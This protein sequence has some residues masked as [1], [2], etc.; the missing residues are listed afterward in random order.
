MRIG[1]ALLSLWAALRWTG[2]FAGVVR[3]RKLDPALRREARRSAVSHAALDIA[4]TVVAVYAWSF[5]LRLQP[6][7]PFVGFLAA[8]LMVAIVAGIAAWFMQPEERSAEVWA[9][10]RLRR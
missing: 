6:V 9:L 10:F 3:L 4:L 1:A 2:L 5:A 8:V 7:E